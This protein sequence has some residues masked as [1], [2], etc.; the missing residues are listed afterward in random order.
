MSRFI[1]FLLSLSL[2]ILP[3]YAETDDPLQGR[4]TRSMKYDI[5]H[6]AQQIAEEN[7]SLFEVD[8]DA[9]PD[10]KDEYLFGLVIPENIETVSSYRF[11]SGFKAGDAIPSWD[12]REHDGVTPVKHQGECG[13]CW[14]FAITG[15]FEHWI[16]IIDKTEVDLSEQDL[17]N[18]NKEGHECKGGWPFDAAGYFIENGAAKEDEEKYKAA[19]S[20]CKC[21][22]SRSYKLT[23]RVKFDQDDSM[24]KSC[25]Y[26]CGSA[27]VCVDADDAAFKSYRSGI[28]NV[29]SKGGQ[30]NHAVLCVGF[31][32]TDGYW[33]I[34]NSW[35]EGWGD[36]GYAKI[37]YGSC[38]LGQSHNVVTLYKNDLISH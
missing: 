37:K 30:P 10:Y 36:K 1:L 34:K 32:D 27:T 22:I 17:I 7:G 11:G 6:K 14:A 18:C 24:L 29:K 38:L 16:K 4:I 3:L 2:L 8:I 35:G 23:D 9:I 28:Y 19:K 33:V 31:N 26:Y 25:V 5:L 12:W 21:C 20:S 15:N 13:S